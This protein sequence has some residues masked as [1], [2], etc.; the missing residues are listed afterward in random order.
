MTM[1]SMT[2][3]TVLGLSLVFS[4]SNEN[5]SSNSETLANQAY[6]AAEAGLD[7]AL[8]VMR[9]NRAPL[10]VTIP[11][12]AD[13]LHQINFGIAAT[14]ISSNTAAENTANAVTYPRLSR[15]LLYSSPTDSGAV[16]LNPGDPANKQLSYQLRIEKV[17]GTAEV[18]ITSIGIAPQGARRTLKLRVMDVEAFIN[19]NNLP[20]IPA[21]VTLLGNDPL[22]SVGSSAATNLYGN[23]CGP[24]GTSEHPIFGAVGP[25]N[26]KHAWDH[27]L[28]SNNKDVYNTTY[29]N[30][31]K[32]SGIVADIS[33]PD[34][35]YGITGQVPFDNNQVKA[36]AFVKQVAKIADR[37]INAN[38]T[39]S[40]GTQDA[41]K[42]ILA[43]GDLTLTGT[44]SG[45]LVVTGN[46]TMNGNF[47]FDGLIIVLGKGG[48]QRNGGGGGEIKGG[49]I[50]AKYDAN[51]LDDSVFDD[52][53][54]LN[55]NGGGNSKIIYCSASIQT[56]LTSL[57]NAALKATFH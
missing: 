21:A 12:A 33:V 32:P 5:L 17:P 49:I 7:E 42:V 51:T 41:S 6:Y 13:P 1:M 45:V 15:W 28:K 37:V 30:Y 44:G 34:P 47:K 9:G 56:A 20:Y 22:A 36:D 16:V 35:A 14:K 53:A 57:K 4:A 10:G 46:L 24:T 43:K 38:E 29:D 31:N 55:T 39:A 11:N 52:D 2:L 48:V 40:L 54:Y 23:D 19:G 50:I 27:S 26:A 8:M 25:D 18:Q 3:M